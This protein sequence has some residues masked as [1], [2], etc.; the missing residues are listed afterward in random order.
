MDS[1]KSGV[2]NKMGYVEG[3]FYLLIRVGNS[4]L[5]SSVGSYILQRHETERCKMFHAQGLYNFFLTF[6]TTFLR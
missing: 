5:L 3:C 6:F 2:T 4:N 1:F